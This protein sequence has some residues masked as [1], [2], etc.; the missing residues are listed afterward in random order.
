M[1][2]GRYVELDVTY[3]NAP[4]AG[5]VGGDIESLTYVDSAADD[6]D[7]VDI[8]L[9]A[10][11]EKWLNNWMPEKG[12]TLRPRIIG[13]DWTAPGDTKVMECG[14]FT[15]D[16]ISYQDAPS[17][18]QVGG[19]SKPGDSNFSELERAT[20]WK[21]TSIKRIGQQ[22]ANRYGLE[23]G[24]DA[25]D[26]D[27]ECSEQDGTDSSYYNDLCKNY[28]LILKVYAKR[29]WV[30][31]RERYKSKPPVATI[32]RTQIKRGS[33]SY[34]TTLSGTYT[35]GH[36]TYTDP[37][38]DT[39]IECSMGGGS[40]IK[41]VNR[42]ASSVLDATIQLC[43]EL[44]N[45]NHGMIKL[46]FSVMGNW[47]VCAGNNISLTGY[48]KIS[49]NYFV[50]KA[51][52]KYSRKSGFTT[53]FECSGIRPPFQYWNVGGKIEHDQGETATQAA[54]AASETSGAAAG[55]A[56]TL[57]KAPLYY[58]ST[59]S[60]PSGY[61]SGTFYI[62]DGIL[63]NGR[64]RIT[65]TAARCGKKPVGKNVTGWVPASYCKGV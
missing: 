60:K 58:G 17:T 28:G 15:L 32:D 11:D 54:N 36:F 50:N 22:I 29:L 45:T 35:G 39:D 53:D 13:H 59:S 62:Y 42:R 3:N 43:A 27:I 46:K 61:K 10:Q 55:T 9:T 8:T 31:D 37:D 63:I 4:F 47:S 20:T 25:E 52:H 34:S 33:L 1:I 40:R 38:K 30:Y 18:L 16:D 57:T 64:Y 12:A 41:N 6:C 21:H 5:Q 24:Y 26:Y 44:N 51:T 14:L 65:N 2:N 23:F 56:V 7:S 19:V 48:G 49:G